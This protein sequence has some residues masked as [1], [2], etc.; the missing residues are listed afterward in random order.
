M[1]VKT[2]EMNYF[3]KF[4]SKLDFCPFRGLIHVLSA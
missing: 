3:K 4:R 1:K 2:I